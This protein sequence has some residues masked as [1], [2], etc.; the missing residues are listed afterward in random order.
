MQSKLIGIPARKLAAMIETPSGYERNGNR[1]TMQYGMGIWND[2][3]RHLTYSRRKQ[4]PS[5]FALAARLRAFQNTGLL[6]SFRPF[7]I[8]M[9]KAIY[10][11]A[12]SGIDLD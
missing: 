6:V 11:E 9:I 2:S 10:N 1:G 3:R 5:C 8:A 12:H 7:W 4:R